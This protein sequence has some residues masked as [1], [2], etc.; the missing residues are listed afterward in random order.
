MYPIAVATV[1][2]TFL[3]A[4]NAKGGAQ[5]GH[6]G[7]A[8][9]MI[10]TQHQGQ[11]QPVQGSGGQGGGN[12]VVGY[13][14]TLQGLGSGPV[15]MVL[16]A[17]LTRGDLQ[18]MLPQKAIDQAF[19]ISDAR[20]DAVLLEKHNLERFCRLPKAVKQAIVTEEAVEDGNVAAIPF[21]GGYWKMILILEGKGPETEASLLAYKHNGVQ[22]N[23]RGNVLDKSG[24]TKNPRYAYWMPGFAMEPE[25]IEIPAPPQVFR[26]KDVVIRRPSS[27]KVEGN[28]P[29][30]LSEHPVFRYAAA[31]SAWFWGEINRTLDDP[32]LEYGDSSFEGPQ[33]MYWKK[34]TPAE[35]E[36]ALTNAIWSDSSISSFEDEPISLQIICAMPVETEPKYREPSWGLPDGTPVNRRRA[37]MILTKILAEHVPVGRHMMAMHARHSGL[38]PRPLVLALDIPVPTAHQR[39][40]A[41][42]ANDAW[43]KARGLVLQEF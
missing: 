36:D 39:I 38:R 10:Q 9:S 12:G 20:E 8:G 43:L 35:F 41:A 25:A 13:T 37:D 3:L 28:D 22:S 17:K 26:H 29:K 42:A 24:K 34:G 16:G 6:A 23:V 5:G 18:V 7:G 4:P 31:L 33:T 11:G 2:T 32:F 14:V 19:E 1:A 15:H 30:A 21:P 27:W 40:D